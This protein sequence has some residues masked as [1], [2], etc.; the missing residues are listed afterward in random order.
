MPNLIQPT[1]GSNRIPMA[2]YRIEKDR[3]VVE[4]RLRK[5]VA[6]Q[7]DPNKQPR[8]HAPISERRD[9]GPG[10]PRFALQLRTL[11]ELMDGKGIER[12]ST[13]AAVDE[14]FKKALKSK[15]KQRH[16]KEFGL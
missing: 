9:G 4:T 14:T 16:Q 5:A 12:P 13:V 7:Q 11:K 15:K 3:D 10:V 2:I 8:H 6:G 1:L